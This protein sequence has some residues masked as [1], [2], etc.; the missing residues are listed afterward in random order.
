MKLPYF[1]KGKLSWYSS[2]YNKRRVK[3]SRKVFDAILSIPLKI[4]NSRFCDKTQ[5]NSAQ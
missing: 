2:I 4:T 1:I 3:R 5:D